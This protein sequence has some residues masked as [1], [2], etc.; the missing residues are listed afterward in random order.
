[1]ETQLVESRT[2]R[3]RFPS[4]KSVPSQSID[5]AFKSCLWDS[6]I[7]NHNEEEN[8]NKTETSF[9]EKSISSNNTN[10][11]GWS[12]LEALSNVSQGNKEP[13]QKE[14]SYVHPQQKRSS[15]VLSPRSLELCTENLGNE[16]GTDIAENGIDMLSS[17]YT[18]GGNLGTREQREPR[19]HLAAMKAKT[20]NFPPPLTTIRG[21]KSLVMRPHREDGRLVIEV[22]K[23]P[24]S[25]SCFHAERSHGRLRL[26]FLNNHAPSFDPEEE[27]G[28]EE[29]SIEENEPTANE[30]G[31]EEELENEMSG[32]IQF[33]EEEEEETEEEAEEEEDDA[34]GCGCVYEEEMKGSDM[35]MYERP[36]RCKEGGDHENNELLLNWG[37]PL[38]VA[39]S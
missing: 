37:E 11:G 2:L 15:L 1:M 16:S 5:L 18:A 3:L 38:W 25:A 14:T 27:E 19:Q 9:Q 4:S 35:R 7:K 21:T 26:C 31:F 10:K 22:T 23:V 13:S 28:E 29:Y 12:F 39:T 32:Q 8:S 20:Q 30:E 34:C 24:P 36:R 6:N 33:L 17:S